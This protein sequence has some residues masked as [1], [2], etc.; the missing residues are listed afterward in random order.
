MARGDA[1]STLQA[2]CLGAALAWAPSLLVLGFA[3]WETPLDEADEFSSE[4]PQE[5]YPS[6]F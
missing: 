6:R 3:L 4:E 2:M 1:M 5:S